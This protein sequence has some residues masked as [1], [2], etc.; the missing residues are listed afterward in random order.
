MKRNL[1]KLIVACG[2]YA[3]FPA[4]ASATPK[5]N[6]NPDKLT[7]ELLIINDKGE[8]CEADASA[9]AA[10]DKSIARYYDGIRE[11]ALR[12]EKQ[13]MTGGVSGS[14][15]AMVASAVYEQCV[16]NG[17]SASFCAS[18]AGRGAELAI[19]LVRE[20]CARRGVDQSTCD[21]LIEQSRP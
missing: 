6:Q 13:A 4:S 12:A 21:S 19:Q 2:A 1:A 9:T 3:L 15:K 5:C 17:A 11:A 10:N 7:G 8:Y 16:A 18:G 20:E 14:T